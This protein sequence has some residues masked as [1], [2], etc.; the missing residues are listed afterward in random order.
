MKKLTSDDKKTGVA[1]CRLSIGKGERN[2]VAF[3]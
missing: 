3:G 1:Y 2:R